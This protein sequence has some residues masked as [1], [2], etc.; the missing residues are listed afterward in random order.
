VMQD[1]TLRES[2]Q[3][4]LERVQLK[5]LRSACLLDTCLRTK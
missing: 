3:F 4:Y 5:I 1:L 2:C